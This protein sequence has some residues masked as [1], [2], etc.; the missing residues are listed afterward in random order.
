L[1][2]DNLRKYFRFAHTS[3][4][5]LLQADSRHTSSARNSKGKTFVFPSFATVNIGILLLLVIPHTT[6]AIFLV[7]SNSCLLD[8][9]GTGNGDATADDPPLHISEV[10]SLSERGGKQLASTVYY[11]SSERNIGTHQLKFIVF[12]NFFLV[13]AAVCFGKLF[14]SF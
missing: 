14:F 13:T 4:S 11:K 12:P 8:E 9:L 3:S 1:R 2:L 7:I 5:R 6:G 10:R